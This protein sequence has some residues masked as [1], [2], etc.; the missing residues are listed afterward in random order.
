MCVRQD[1]TKTAK[2]SSKQDKGGKNEERVDRRWVFVKHLVTGIGVRQAESKADGQSF[3]FLE[4]NRLQI[5]FLSEI[6]SL[7]CDSK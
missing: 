3:K 7:S 2:G 5:D 4:I 6:E 1:E